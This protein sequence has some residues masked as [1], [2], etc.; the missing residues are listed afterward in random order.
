M[1]LYV[2]ITEAKRLV[3][4]YFIYA[5]TL[6]HRNLQR[7]AVWTM[8]CVGYDETFQREICEKFQNSIV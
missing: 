5:L 2:L 7:I 8:E 4:F 1:K 6:N 3:E